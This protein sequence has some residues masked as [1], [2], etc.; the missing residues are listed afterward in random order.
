MLYDQQQ[1]AKRDNAMDRDDDVKSG[2][3]LNSDEDCLKDEAQH[4]YSTAI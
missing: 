4:I 1:K 2:K 3:D